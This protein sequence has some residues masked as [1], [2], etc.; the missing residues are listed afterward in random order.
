MA[1]E[2]GQLIAL[3][4]LERSLE[5]NFFARQWH[6]IASS[7]LNQPCQDLWPHGYPATEIA[8]VCE[9]TPLLAFLQ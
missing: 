9:R 6:E 1:G 3:P 7:R 8:N 2:H 4:L 5:E